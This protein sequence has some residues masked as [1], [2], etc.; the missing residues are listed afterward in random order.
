MAKVPLIEDPPLDPEE[1]S[2]RPYTTSS[3]TEICR[4]DTLRK[5]EV[6]TMTDSILLLSITNSFLRRK[7]QQP[8]TT[9]T[10]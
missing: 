1:S 3:D 8:T 6:T 5:R 7:K 4:S 10:Q 9:L 2:G